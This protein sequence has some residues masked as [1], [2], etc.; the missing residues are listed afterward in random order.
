MLVEILSTGDEV[1]TGAV[2]DS[3]AAHIAEVMFGAGFA[4][5]RHIC[6]GDDFARLVEI[7][8]EI[9]GRAD[10][11]VVTGGLGPT[12]DDLT[13]AVMAEVA[14][15]PLM[16][17]PEADAS[18]TEFF[19]KRNRTRNLKDA[20]Q[21]MLPRG[22]ECMVNAVGTA[23]GFMMQ[24]DRCRFFCLPGVPSEMQWMLDAAVMP[25]IDRLRGDAPEASQ[26]KIFTVF[27]LPES[28]VGEKLAGFDEK[29]PAVKLGTRASFPVI[30][31]KLYAR[32]ENTEIVNAAIAEAAA[33]V[34]AQ[35]SKW[36]FS[37][38]GASMEQTVG[39]LLTEKGMTVAVAESCTG[40]LISHMLT[41]VPGSSA[42]FLS[43][44]VTYANQAKTALLGVARETLEQYG[45]VHENT[46]AEMAEGVRRMAGSDFGV[47]TSG[48]AGPDGGT[49]EKP[50]GTV[51]IGIAGPDG[52]RTRRLELSFGS[53]GK[54]KTI[55]AVAAL[56]L[57]RRALV[58]TPSRDAA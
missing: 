37:S 40:G 22:A 18:I 25:R 42:Y 19:E 41:N 10:V 48:I 43:S 30:Q 13:S 32:G 53:R 58:G 54:N 33:W 7:V 17:D 44:A 1:L 11:A 35:L 46:A 56:E 9:A 21:A 14:G 26:L 31:V 20:K 6:V 23:P 39:R 12:A 3:N 57:L 51:C 27:G 34:S 38:E 29:F 45:A 55:F 52:V 28:M 47:S 4:V 49:P 8:R 2:V 16:L 24:I 36:I 15:A 50:V 5:T